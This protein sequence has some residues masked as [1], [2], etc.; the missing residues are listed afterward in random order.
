MEILTLFPPFNQQDP[1]SIAQPSWAE[2]IILSSV[3]LGSCPLAACV[4]LSYNLL[5]VSPP[6][7]QGREILEG[8]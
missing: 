1:D 5:S 2:E 6:A 7:L 4:S 8:S 3:A